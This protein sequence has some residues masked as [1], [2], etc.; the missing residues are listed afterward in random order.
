M[1]SFLAIRGTLRSNLTV[2]HQSQ[3]AARYSL[4]TSVLIVDHCKCGASTPTQS[5]ARYPLLTSVLI[6]VHCNK[7]SVVG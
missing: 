4:L 3:S 5:A 1:R 6:V 7:A 2:E